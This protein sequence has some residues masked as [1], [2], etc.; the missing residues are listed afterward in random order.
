MKLVLVGGSG[1]LG[2]HLAR[3][4]CASGHQCV[5]LTRDAQRCRQFS[6]IEG[7]RVQQVD[8]YSSFGKAQETR[9]PLQE[10]GTSLSSIIVANYLADTTVA[11]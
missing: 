7:A 8:V 10:L 4:L 2:F 3:A 11:N 9:A 6:L 1:F 5:I